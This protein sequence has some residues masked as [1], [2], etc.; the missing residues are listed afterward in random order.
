MSCKASPSIDRG[1]GICIRVL[2]AQSGTDGA[3]CETLG[4]GEEEVAAIQERP[5]DSWGSRLRGI[6]TSVFMCSSPSLEPQRDAEEQRYAEEANVQILRLAVL[7]QD[8][9]E[10]AALRTT[11]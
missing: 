3:G 4:S 1:Q 6:S 10:V 8:D 2:R 5:V 7:A 11:H 9:K